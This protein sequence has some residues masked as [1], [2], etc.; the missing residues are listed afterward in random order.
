MQTP[1]ID[2]VGMAVD[3][4]DVAFY[5]DSDFLVLM[6]FHL[7]STFSKSIEGDDEHEDQE[8]ESEYGEDN[9][10]CVTKSKS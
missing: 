9:V 1:L 2:F 10:V 8:L 5:S 3:A 7:L 6:S 4:V